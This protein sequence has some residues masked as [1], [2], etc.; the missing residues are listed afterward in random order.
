[1]DR[2]VVIAYI[3]TLSNILISLTLFL[4]P[5]F[6][7]TST[8]DFFTVPKQLLIV[9]STLILLVIWCIRILFEKKIIAVV[10]PLNLP[11]A[12]FGIIIIIS[13]ILSPNRYDSLL[14]SIPLVSS[15][16]LAFIIINFT[17]NERSFS[18]IISAYIIG[19]TLSALITIA[20]SFKFY[21]I[22]ITATQNQFFNTI[23][24][25]FQQLIYFIPILVFSIFYLARK[26]GFPKFS[27][28]RNIAGDY[29]FFIQL[30]SIMVIGIATAAI[31]Y[32]IA[33]LP[34]KPVLLPY[35]YGF[36]IAFASISQD[37]QRFIL[38]LLF[39]SGYGTFLT[40]F[41]R[42]KLASFNLEQ[43]I[44][45]LAFSFSSSYFLEIIATTGL[46]GALSYL[47][48]ILSFLKTKTVTNPLFIS[49]FAAF[50]LS[51]ILPVSFMFVAALFL[52]SGIYITYLNL[53]DDKRVY[54]VSLSLVSTKKGIPSFE[55]N[56]VAEHGARGASMILPLIIAVILLAVSGFIGYYAIK[57]TS[58][59]IKFAQS[60]A[61]AQANNGQRTYE[62]QT[63]AINEFP[64]RSDYHRIFSQVNLALANSVASG[65]QPGSSPS[66]QVQQ[67][68]VA[69]LQQSINSGRNAVVLSPRTSLNWQNLGIVYRSLINVGQNADQFALASINQA[70]ALDPYNPNLYILAGGVYYQLQ[71][72]DQ[73]ANQFQ[74][75]INLKRDFANAYYNLGHAYESKG[76]FENALTAY[77]VVKQ[78][79]QDNQENIVKIDAEIKTLEDKIG[80]Q[81]Q[82]TGNQ[83]APE[84]EQGPLG[85]SESTTD[86]PEQDPPIKISP[87]PGGN[88]TPTP[89][90][91]GSPTP[92]SS[93]SPTE[94]Q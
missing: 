80:S 31:I 18:T 33:F 46:L 65:I 59:D 34:N 41:T 14:Q 91:S 4:L 67:N 16:I 83:V 54:D 43:N 78:L 26:F 8:T 84:T 9:F 30:L 79:S 32:Q 66:A 81:A 52:T 35:V 76:D 21:V 56:P 93:V 15:I 90:A 38:A 24:P 57:L 85:I 25:S 89:E 2:K 7:L 6:F 23:G 64:Y 60:L 86:I 17:K 88:T 39:G 51:L 87:P 12:L 1:M 28:P 29:G 48:V 94:T 58:S 68:I 37:A 45:S 69:L 49:I 74:V 72:W 19:A 71:Q 13:S 36:Q 3:D 62:L 63:A 55:A 44:W 5:L 77:Q 73:A 82:N 20:Y 53:K 42:F 50:V 70:I 10:S 40:D 22:P 27:V 11:L 92:S 75:A 61:A 47:W